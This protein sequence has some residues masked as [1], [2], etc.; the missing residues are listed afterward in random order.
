MFGFVLGLTSVGAGVFFGMTLV[1]LFPLSARKVVGTD[2]MHG[3]L[4]TT[5]AAAGT[6]LWG[7]PT[8]HT[9]APS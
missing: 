8:T 6:I 3:A 1:L 2:I 4:V 9:W 5:A 7:H